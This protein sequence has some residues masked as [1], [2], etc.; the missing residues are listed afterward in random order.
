MGKF[1]AI[2]F[3]SMPISAQRH[4]KITNTVRKITL[5]VSVEVKTSEL[6]GATT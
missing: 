5:V 4:Y 3:E 6:K 1:D 2:S